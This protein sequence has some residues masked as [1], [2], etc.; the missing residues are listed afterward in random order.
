MRRVFRNGEAASNAKMTKLQPA[1]ERLQ[2]SF[3]KGGFRT[4]LFITRPKSI[5]C[6]LWKGN[7]IERAFLPR[8]LGPRKF[9]FGLQKEFSTA[10]LIIPARAIPVLSFLK[11]D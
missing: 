11:S 2:I 10:Y 6:G 9:V 7:C 1:E 5:R 3:G 8:H 4:D